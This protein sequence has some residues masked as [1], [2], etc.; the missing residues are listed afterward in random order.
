MRER[1][2]RHA[3]R[4]PG[5]VLVVRPAGDDRRQPRRADAQ[6]PRP[7]QAGSARTACASCCA[8]WAST[9]DHRNRY[10]REFSGG[11]L[12]RIAI[13][14]ALALS[15]QAARAR[16]AGEQPRRLDP[17]RRHQPA[18]RPAGRARA[19]VPLHRPRPRARA[20]RERPHRGDVPR[21]DRRGGPGRR[22]LRAARSTP[23]PRRCSRRS[24][25]PNPQRQRER[26]RIVL[27]GDIPSPAAPPSGCRFH[28]RCRYA[29]EP[30][31][32]RRS[33]RRSRR[34]TAPRVAC[35]LHTDGPRARRSDGPGSDRPR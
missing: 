22:G 35:H 1:A 19:R 23:T 28:T 14:R 24:R 25:S 21:A 9:R 6:L 17:G 32:T 11:Q 3:D 4:V 34:P 13:A 8:P 29:F 30:C 5:P 10:P 20:P 31:R 7:R 18:R 2:P 15:P 27:Q 16:R 26:E 12:Q 33:A